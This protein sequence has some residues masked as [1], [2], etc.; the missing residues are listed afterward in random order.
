MLTKL[1]LIFL[2]VF[3]WIRY[4][5]KSL[6]SSIIISAVITFIIDIVTRLVF[7]RKEIK[8][9]Q[10]IKEKEDA[11]NMFLSLATTQDYLSFFKKFG[12]DDCIKHKDYISFIENSKKTI[13]YPFLSFSSLSIND[14]AQ[15]MKKVQKSKPQKIIIVAGEISKECFQF[16]KIFDEEIELLDKYQTYSKLYKPANIYPEITRKVKKNK[17][18]TIKELLAHSFNRARCK[19]YILSAFALLFCSLFVKA[20][21]YYTIVTSLLLIFAIISYT[22][23]FDKYTSH[24]KAI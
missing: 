21:L 13:L 23:P 17:K 20:T 5:V 19:G 18:L 24:K 14:V 4:F 10:K 3:V 7:K 6:I 16:I 2:A 9:S 1:F 22:N 8:L 15:I 11:E 12:K